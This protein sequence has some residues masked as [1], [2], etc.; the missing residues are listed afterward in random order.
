MEQI[1]FGIAVISLSIAAYLIRNGWKLSGYA[2]TLYRI[3]TFL[4][5]QIETNEDLKELI[6]TTLPEE[7]KAELDMCLDSVDLLGKSKKGTE[8][9]NERTSTEGRTDGNTTTGDNGKTE[10]AD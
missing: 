10:V 2:I 7:L 5:Q 9:D 4:V 1:L 8:D 6:K 3:I